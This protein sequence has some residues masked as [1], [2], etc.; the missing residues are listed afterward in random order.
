MVERVR[1]VI[2]RDNKRTKQDIR[3]DE[4][5]ST[6]KLKRSKKGSDLS[7]Q[8]PVNVTAASIELPQDSSSVAEIKRAIVNEIAKGKTL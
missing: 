3:M 2:K 4:L 1:N 5:S 8:Y 6:R 7:K